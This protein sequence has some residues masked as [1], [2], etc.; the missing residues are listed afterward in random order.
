MA[1]GRLIALRARLGDR[2]GA[3]RAYE[4]FSRR[5][6]L[7]LGVEPSAETREL[8][9]ALRGGAKLEQSEFGTPQASPVL[10]PAGAPAAGPPVRRR[11]SGW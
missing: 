11:W 4:E 6:A 9:R 8:V 10:S 5:V 7:D 2:V 1:L 3:L